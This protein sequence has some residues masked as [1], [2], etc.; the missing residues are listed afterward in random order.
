LKAAVLACPRRRVRSR[1]REQ[2]M[3]APN[4]FPHHGRADQASPTEHEHAHDPSLLWKPAHRMA[5]RAIIAM[6][7]L[8]MNIAVQRGVNTKTSQS[9]SGAKSGEADFLRNLFRSVRTGAA[10]AS[11]PQR[12]CYHF[13]V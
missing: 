11:L 12:M 4:E 3:P 2:F 1:Q 9:K 6:R 8:R 7:C 10:Y 13:Q 5:R